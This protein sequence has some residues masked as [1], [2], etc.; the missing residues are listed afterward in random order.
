MKEL[1][2][3]AKDILENSNLD[4]NNNEK[5]KWGDINKAMS[6]AGLNPRAIMSVL[7]KL[8]GKAIK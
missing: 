3:K 4:E 8:K 2:E 7:S 6:G 5:Y 1:I